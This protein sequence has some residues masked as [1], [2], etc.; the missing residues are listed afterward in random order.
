MRQT[1]RKGFTLIE[2]LIVVV[3][4]GILAA[5]VVPQFNNASEDAQLSNVR[6]QLSTVRG[7]IELYRVRNNGALPELGDGADAAA[8][9]APL[10]GEE[11]LRA[12]PI[13]PRNGL[14]TISA[15][16]DVTEA[17]AQADTAGAFGWYYN[18]VTGNIFAGGLDEDGS[19]NAPVGTPRW[20][21]Q[22]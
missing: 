18:T 16:D 1:I 17:T 12:A 7:Q 19:D 14:G 8:N 2:I 15:G 20:H 9:W 3:I 21:P 13:N 22:D 11:F 10:I 4:L 5:I 6:S